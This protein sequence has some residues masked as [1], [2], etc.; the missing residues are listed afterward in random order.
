MGM[1]MSTVGGEA[2]DDDCEE[3]LEAPQEEHVVEGHGVGFLVGL[4]V[5]MMGMGKA[6]ATGM[7]FGSLGLAGY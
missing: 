7:V 3:D 2:D 4:V 1:G 6:R 5:V